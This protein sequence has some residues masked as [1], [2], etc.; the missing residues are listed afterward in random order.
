MLWEKEK[1]LISCI[2]S[3]PQ[4]EISR[5]KV[6]FSLLSTDSLTLYQ[7]IPTLNNTEKETFWKHWEKKENAGNQH[8]LLF[9]QCFL[10]FSNRVSSF[11]SI[12]FCCLLIFS[13]PT[14][15]KFCRFGKELW[16][17]NRFLSTVN[18]FLLLL[19]LSQTS[20]FRPFQTERVC[21]RQFRL[22]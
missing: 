8:F 12:L 16:D 6:T 13:I 18:I 3:L 7:T 17:L 19:T 10:L 15:L 2:F 20:N 14:S 9:P 4:K 5:F 21:R 11:D 22:K 1:M